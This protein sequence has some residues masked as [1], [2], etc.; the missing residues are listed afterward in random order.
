M[1]VKQK[2]TPSLA[3]K[4]S[5]ALQDPKSASQKTIKSLAARVLVDEKNAP[6]KHSK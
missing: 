5:K 1:V 4:A 2:P 6:K 3:S